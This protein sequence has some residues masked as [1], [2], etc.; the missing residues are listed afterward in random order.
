MAKKI[1]LSDKRKQALK[2]NFG[3]IEPR[4]KSEQQYLNKIKAGKARAAKGIKDNSGKY[5]SNT[6]QQEVI[7][8]LAASKGVSSRTEKNKSKRIEVIKQEAK[9]TDKELKKFYEINRESYDRIIKT[10]SL[11]EVTRNSDQIENDINNYKG[12]IYINRNGQKI[13]VSK[14]EAIQEVVKF[15]QYLASH[16]STVEI[17]IT[18]ELTFD[19]RMILPIADA[20]KLYKDMKEKLGVNNMDD[21]SDAIADMDGPELNELLSEIFEDE[22]YDE[23][24]IVVITSPKK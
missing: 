10:G 18:P 20:K 1:I 8:G 4:N 2:N 9:I 15:K 12:K 7:K 17:V 24:D 14:S 22:G 19:G 21:M 6:L 3:S 5:I 23:G 11:K 13:K 16:F